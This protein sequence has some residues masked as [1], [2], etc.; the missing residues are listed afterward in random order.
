MFHT[1]PELRPTTSRDPGT[2]I[3]ILWIAVFA[4]FVVALMALGGGDDVLT[5]H[6]MVTPAPWVGPV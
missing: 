2:A 3:F 6:R 5:A 4:I 1:N